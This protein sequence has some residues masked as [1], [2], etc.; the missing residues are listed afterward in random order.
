MESILD[1]RGG[2]KSRRQNSNSMPH[3]HD[4]ETSRARM[5]R[6]LSQRTRPEGAISGRSNEQTKYGRDD[7]PSRP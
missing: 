3:E 5:G 1:N 7:P 4:C 2:V 6:Y